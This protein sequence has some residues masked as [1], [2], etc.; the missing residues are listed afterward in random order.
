MPHHLPQRHGPWLLRELR[1]LGLNLVVQVQPALLEQHADRGGSEH[2]GGCSDP[3]PGSRRDA[4]LRLEVRPAEALGPRDVAV[5]ANRH[6][7]P[8]QVLLGERRPHDLPR[9][10]HRLGPPR[11]WVRPSHRW[12][13][14]RLGVQRRGRSACENGEPHGYCDEP[15]DGEGNDRG[16]DLERIPLV[17]HVYLRRDF[18]L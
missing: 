9:A 1:D 2:R 8:W 18:T 11:R 14:L 4:P 12:R 15:G 13:A 6:R 17:R 7:K 5:H 16:Q 3:E 10:V